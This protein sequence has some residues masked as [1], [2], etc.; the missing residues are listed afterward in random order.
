[1]KSL[2]IANSSALLSAIKRSKKDI[3]IL[4]GSPLSSMPDGSGIP[5]V[6]GMLN[7]IDEYLKND[8]G[9][10]E[11]YKN[12][13]LEKFKSDNERY[14]KSF[15]FIVD[16]IGPDAANELV[17]KSV[18]LS[19]TLDQGTKDKLNLDDLNKIQSDPSFWLI[20]PATEALA[21]L[22]ANHAL[23]R[24][25][26]ITTNFDP[27]ISVSLKKIGFT[28]NRIVLH[29]DSSIDS[30]HSDNVNIVHM[31][32]FWT[33]SD[34]M[35]TGQQLTVDR[36]K[37]KASLLRLLRKKV[38]FVV[39]YSGWDDI[40]MQA[41]QDI[42]ND[43]N[44]DLDVIWAFFEEN[45]V[46][47]SKKYEKLINIVQPAIGRSRF[48]MYGGIDCHKFMPQLANDLHQANIGGKSSE[49]KDC[50][51][52][53]GSVANVSDTHNQSLDLFLDKETDVPTWSIDIEPAHLYIRDVERQD[54]I[55]KLQHNH[56]VNLVCDWGLGRDEF[57]KTLVLDRSSNFYQENLY[58]IDFNNVR[59]KSDLLNNIES[60]FGFGLQTLINK[61]GSEKSI[62]AFDNF[63]A[64]L[65]S[66]DE[67]VPISDWLVSIINE[68]NP[69]CRVIICTNRIFLSNKPCVELSALEEFDVRSY[70]K[71]HSKMSKNVEHIDEKV[72]E[73]LI[74]LS[75]GVPSFLDKYISDLNLFSINEIYDSHFTPETY[76][77][78]EG[79]NKLYPEELIKRIEYLSS[80]AEEH[81]AR[82]YELLKIMSILE[83][84]DSF[85][86][87]KRSHPLFSFRQSHLKELHEFGLLE[88]RS[89][90][91]GI[92]NS[93]GELGDEKLHYITPIVRSYV[94]S[95]LNYQEIYEITK[96]LADIHFGKKW[97]EGVI[98]LCSV[99]K[100]LLRT[101]SKSIGS[102]ALIAIHLL[103]CAIETNNGRTIQSAFTICELFCDALMRHD[104]HREIINFVS[105]VHSVLSETDKINN[106]IGIEILEGKSLRMT[107]QNEQ[108]EKIFYTIY[109]KLK[110]ERP[111]LHKKQLETSMTQLAFI[112][113]KQNN[114]IDASEM[115]NQVLKINKHNADARII[116]ATTS[117]DVSI[118][119]LTELEK[120]LRTKKKNVSADNVCFRLCDKQSTDK[121][122]I[123]W[124]DKVLN[125]TPDQ[126]NKYRAIVRKAALYLKSGDIDT[127]SDVEVNILHLSYMYSFSQKLTAIF[128]MAHTAL[129]GL[130]EERGHS[131]MLL[132]LFKHSSLFW[133]IYDDYDKEKA[134]GKKIINT[135]KGLMPQDADTYQHKY[136]LIRVA[137]LN[138]KKD[139]LSV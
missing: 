84:G 98:N 94:Y 65:L 128:N 23:V 113:S 32:G 25:P 53:Q 93:L 19:T 47:I 54:I 41:L 24:G 42:I 136:A 59:S 95:K 44:A 135:L 36:P 90:S 18:L 132:A 58:R 66:H 1:M 125:N 3:A 131:S 130:Y 16:Y 123:F 33:D 7:I 72:Y 62:I 49:V 11:D 79:S 45:E 29:S 68:F 92:L 134:C 119:E 120:E 6:H 14:Q 107:G 109:S 115:A 104:K 34:T 21:N 28:S 118:S 103:R 26:I 2:R 85:T 96:S 97:R 73:S 4:V 70:I 22:I 30:Y 82:S 129:W 124:L 99:T 88:S 10:Y 121:V 17:R 133:R 69:K 15:E 13:I 51:G 67:M 80:S 126:Y 20:P 71:N 117:D 138:A 46:A 43:D 106:I 81:T 78:T 8:N 40:F 55:G 5:T 75:Q 112:Y 127:L 89:I 122:K 48:R 64:D 35:H 74:A 139:T 37:L 12:I 105:Q 50:V 77:K 38:L 31:H 60:D 27:L 87:L 57:I 100:D 56:S 52:F 116:V 108:A 86:N 76:K 61:I 137:Q 101:S 91:K 110:N 111:R 39:G 9:L 83:Y 114:L 102:S 63:D